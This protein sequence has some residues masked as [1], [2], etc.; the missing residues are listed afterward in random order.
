[1]EDRVKSF[2]N[3]RNFRDFGGYSGLDGAPVRTNLLFRSAHLNSLSEAG[4]AYEDAVS[5]LLGEKIDHRFLEA[6]KKGLFKRLLG[7]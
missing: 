3:V 4:Q 7:V 2:E 5:R 1:M 6:Q